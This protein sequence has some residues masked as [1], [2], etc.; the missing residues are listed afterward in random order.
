[1]KKKLTGFLGFGDKGNLW[2]CDRCGKQAAIAYGTNISGLFDSLTTGDFCFDC[3]K[4]VDTDA[5]HLWISL[6]GSDNHFRRTFI[7]EMDANP[8][9][10]LDYCG[11]CYSYRSIQK[12]GSELKATY[13]QIRTKNPT[14]VIAVCDVENKENPQLCKHDYVRVFNNEKNPS[15]SEVKDSKRLLKEIQANPIGQMYGYDSID[16]NRSTYG[17]SCYWCC[18]CG[19]SRTITK[20]QTL[21]TFG[22]DSNFPSRYST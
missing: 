8:P 10:H 6:N 20:G 15:S 9:T 21:P 22:T 19:H 3:L 12:I 11:K 2:T 17:F 4:I 1:M 13:Y 16:M 7:S 5:T 14:S 18:K